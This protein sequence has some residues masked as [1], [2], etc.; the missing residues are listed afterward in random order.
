M[1]FRDAVQTIAEMMAHSPN[2]RENRPD[3]RCPKCILSYVL[4]LPLRDGICSECGQ[5]VDTAVGPEPPKDLLEK[6]KKGEK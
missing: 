5:A 2:H 3:E 4:S 6:F 1:S